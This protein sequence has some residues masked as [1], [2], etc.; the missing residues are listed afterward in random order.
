MYTPPRSISANKGRKEGASKRNQAER[1]EYEGDEDEL[2]RRD[3][4]LERRD[5]ESGERR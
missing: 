1:G 5:D 3:D 2:G 4:E